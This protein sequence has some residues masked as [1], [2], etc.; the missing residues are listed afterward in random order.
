MA[1]EQAE[2]GLKR[3]VSW[4]QGLFIAMGVPI[5]ILPSLADVSNIVWGLCIFV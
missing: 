4:K 1:E 5:L 3:S 2:G